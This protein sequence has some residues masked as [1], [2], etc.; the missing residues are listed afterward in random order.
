MTGKRVAE[1]SVQ[2]SSISMY[3]FRIIIQVQDDSCLASRDRVT[4]YCVH[5]EV[6]PGIT[7]DISSYI[8]W[9][10]YDLTAEQ[11]ELKYQQR[12]LQNK[13]DP[14]VGRLW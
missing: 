5:T 14:G 3:S 11:A 7:E 4:R 12:C 2:P 8:V 1:S 6:M 10:E 13:L 9:G